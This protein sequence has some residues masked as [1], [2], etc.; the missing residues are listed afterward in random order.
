MSPSDWRGPKHRARRPRRLHHIV[1]QVTS[2]GCLP[3][4]DSHRAGASTRGSDGCIATGNMS[5]TRIRQGSLI[6]GGFQVSIRKMRRVRFV[7][8]FTVHEL[9]RGAP[10]RC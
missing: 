4:R 8:A 6:R 2:Y 9:L 1:V 3:R 5:F 10:D 7:T